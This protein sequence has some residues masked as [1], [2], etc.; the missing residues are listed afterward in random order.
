MGDCSRSVPKSLLR[1][2]DRFVARMRTPNQMN[3]GIMKQSNGKA[4]SRPQCIA[5]FGYPQACQH[6]RGYKDKAHSIIQ[7]SEFNKHG[8]PALHGN[9]RRDCSKPLC[10]PHVQSEPY[11]FPPCQ[12]DIGGPSGSQNEEKHLAPFEIPSLP[13]SSSSQPSGEGEAAGKTSGGTEE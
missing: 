3:G 6:K 8:Q 5:L 11:F 12:D 1:V 9:R 2:T 7:V 4:F 10:L 13:P